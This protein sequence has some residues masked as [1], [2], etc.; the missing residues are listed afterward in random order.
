[1]SN[2]LVLGDNINTD[3]IIPAKR[4]T[5]ADPNHLRRYALEHIVG[6]D[7]LHSYTR[8]KAGRNFGCGSSREHAAIA[9]NAAGIELIEA[10][11]F[12]EIFFRNC[13]NTGIPLKQ[14]GETAPDPVIKTITAAGG[15]SEF[16]KQRKAGAITLP[17]TTSTT[18]AMTACEKI[19]AKASGMKYVSPG[20]VVFVKADLAMS[21]DAVAG[22]V[23]SMFYKTFGAN[24]TVWDSKKI[25]LVADHFIQVNDI[26]NDPKTRILHHSMRQFAKEQ[27]CIILDEVSPGEAQG[28][29][30][31]L[32]PE[33]G[34]VRPGMVIAGT[35]S[36]SCTYG[37]FGCFS[38]GIGTTDMANLFATGE[39]WLKVPKTVS[40]HL[41]GRLNQT[42][43]AKDIMLHLIGLIGCDGATGC[44]IQFHGPLLET[45]PIDERITLSNMAIECGAMCGYISND[46]ANENYLNRAGKVHSVDSPAT[47]FTNDPDAIFSKEIHIDASTLEPQIACPPSPDKVLGISQ[48]HNTKITKA[49]IGSCT[50]GKLHDIHQ[51]AFALKGRT[52]AAGVELYVVPATQDILKQA[53]QLG[54]IKTLET[55]GATILKSGCGA[56]INA[57]RGTLNEN[58]VGIFATNRN[59][60]GRSGHSSAKNFLASP[61]VVAVS[62]V[63]GYISSSVSAAYNGELETE[64]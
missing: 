61:H 46:Q 3:D 31:V 13:I 34:F 18:R 22:P 1:M 53:T 52:V 20:E 38:L 2:T 60:N 50:G 7:G 5:S 54:Y 62:A 27:N 63:N 41:H 10:D 49:Y 28:I 64:H 45:L 6:I 48:L 43:T 47:E 16:N 14:S 44:V 55:A 59:F 15:L 30:H 8:I 4:C 21:H 35:D 23:A 42:V 51:A 26:R 11:S 36:H 57:G 40:V 33:Q 12:A 32:L 56:C 17:N 29:C 25:V 24:A 19:I 58:E 37:A 39:F 9:L